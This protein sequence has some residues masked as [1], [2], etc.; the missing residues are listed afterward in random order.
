[1]LTMNL[2]FRKLFF[3]IYI[4]FSC[5]I[6]TAQVRTAHA[7]HTQGTL[8]KF[9]QSLKFI[10][11]YK[12]LS[13]AKSTSLA[14][15]VNKIMDI[16]CQSSQLNPPVGFDAEVDVAASDLEFKTAKPQLK[17][18]CYLRYLM[19]DNTGQ[20]KKSMDGADLNLWI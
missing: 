11:S 4:L 19:K 13:D 17:V 10:R 9:Q 3:L 1:M 15:T 18:F 16:V 5:M 12:Y 6:A 20:V 7:E 8:K 2:Y 14:N